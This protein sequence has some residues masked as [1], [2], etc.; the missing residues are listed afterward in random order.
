MLLISACYNHAL[1][2]V[3]ISRRNFLKRMLWAS[4]AA[5]LGGA[6]P[7]LVE[8]HRVEVNHLRLAV[9]N[10]PRA[11]DGLTIAHM[12]DLHRSPFVSLD[13]LDECIATANSLE[14]DL[15]VFTGDYITHGMRF[16]NRFLHGDIDIGCPATLTEESAR[17]M[18]RARAKHGVFA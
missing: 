4:G 6:Y 13:Y 14:P 10:L 1:V 11:W 3:S 9:A 12:T 8:P 16:R 17:C 2:T 5:S 7:L 18:S 15:T